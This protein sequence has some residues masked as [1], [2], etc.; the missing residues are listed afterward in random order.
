MTTFSCYKVTQ[1]FTSIFALLSWTSAIMEVGRWR[2]VVVGEVSRDKLV[3]PCQSV[4]VLQRLVRLYRPMLYCT[5]CGAEWSCFCDKRASLQLSGDVS[6]PPFQYLLSPSGSITHRVF[7]I[8][9]FNFSCFEVTFACVL[10]LQSRALD[11]PDSCPQLSV[12]SI[13]IVLPW[14]CV[15]HP[16][17]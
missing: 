14:L 9:W 8:V 16:Y 7:P 10:E 13:S 11:F 15:Y 3:L 4:V 1:S 2:L 12:Y 5:R 17:N 6:R